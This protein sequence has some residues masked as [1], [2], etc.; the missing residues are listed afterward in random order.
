VTAAGSISPLTRRW[1]RDSIASIRRWWKY[2]G[3]YARSLGLTSEQFLAYGDRAPGRGRAV[4]Q[5]FWPRVTV[6]TP[7][8]SPYCTA[9]VTRKMA[10]MWPVSLDECDRSVTNGIHTRSWIS[11]EMSALL[12]RLPGPQWARSPRYGSLA[13]HRPHSGP[14]VVRVHEH[15]RERMVNYARTGWPPRCGREAHRRGD[16]G[17]RR[18]SS[19]ALTIGSPPLRHLQAGHAAA[20][21]FRPAA[22]HSDRFETA[23]ATPARRQGAPA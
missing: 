9:R 2:F 22:A 18:S 7:M 20:A 1:R 6:R 12:N 3:A 14:G 15:R 11:M 21:R 13:A 10:H 23:G 5:R 17:G 19:P 8:A 16:H 4:Q